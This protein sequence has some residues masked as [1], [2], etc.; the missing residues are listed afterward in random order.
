MI[1]KHC[2]SNKKKEK[3]KIEDISEAQYCQHWRTRAEAGVSVLHLGEAA[4][5][6]AIT[7]GPTPPLQGV[8]Q[9]SPGRG[10]QQ[11]CWG[12]HVLFAG[13]PARPWW[14]NMAL[15]VAPS[16]GS[17]PGSRSGCGHFPGV[18]EGWRFCIWDTVGVLVSL[19]TQGNLGGRLRQV[20]LS[21]V[22]PPGG[23]KCRINPPFH[24]RY[25]KTLFFRMKTDLFVLSL[26][27]E[28]CV[29]NHNF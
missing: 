7:P 12:T 28:R 20:G 19:F 21:H 16:Q 1:N 4:S 14:R 25:G 5:S 11:V 22:L 6:A 2:K 26:A 10:A 15:S 17:A 13:D 9:G 29:W 24:F 8:D 18:G 27:E 23:G 3:S